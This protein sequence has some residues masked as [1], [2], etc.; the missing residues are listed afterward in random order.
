[1]K[2]V[3]YF[4]IAMV[5]CF[6]YA[7]LTVSAQTINGTLRKDCG[8]DSYIIFER[9]D[10]TPSFWVK[11]ENNGNS[12]IQVDVAANYGNDTSLILE[13]GDSFVTYLSSVNNI[14][15]KC[16]GGNTDSKLRLT[17]S[18]AFK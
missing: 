6:C 1:M 4:L 5:F 11:F 10:F 18:I 12:K 2:I 3:R 15:V 17:Y 13:I 8:T 7:V 9:E 16:L 14:R